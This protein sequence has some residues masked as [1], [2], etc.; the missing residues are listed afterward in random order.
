MK[1][2]KKLNQKRI[3]RVNR[4]AAR[5]K[6]TAIWPRLVVNRTNR[7]VHAQL[8]DDAKGHTLVS[9]TSFTEGKKVGKKTEQAFAAGETLAKRAL[10]KGIKVA[11][12]DRRASKFHG[13]VKAFAEGARK[14]GLKI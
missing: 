11:K 13:R 10:E 4:V 12:F 5:S 2:R 3:R 1:T 6:G 14:G 9:A 7:Y 8:I